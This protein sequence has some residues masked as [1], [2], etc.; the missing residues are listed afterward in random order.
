MALLV[1]VGRL[2]GRRQ[3]S[4]ASRQQDSHVAELQVKD[5]LHDLPH[6]NQTPSADEILDT[7]QLTNVGVFQLA[8]YSLFLLKLFRLCVYV[9]YSLQWLM[10]V[11]TE[12]NPRSIPTTSP[13]NEE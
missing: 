7:A 11:F 13:H 3:G 12:M 1:A 2:T 4:G 10:S 9:R 5:K 8:T 6:S